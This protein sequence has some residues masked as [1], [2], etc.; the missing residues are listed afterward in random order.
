MIAVRAG[1]DDVQAAFELGAAGARATGEPLYRAVRR[2]PP[3]RAEM[4]RSANSRTRIAAAPAWSI[5]PGL[6]IALVKPAFAP[7]SGAATKSPA[8]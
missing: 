7:T 4:T 3:E 8:S 2:A 1:I 5:S 6:K